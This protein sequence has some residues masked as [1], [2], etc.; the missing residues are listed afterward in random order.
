MRANLPD[1]F[2]QPAVKRWGPYFVKAA[3]LL[4]LLFLYTRVAP[5]L[6]AIGI[7]L[8]WTAL[9]A[10][11]AILAVYQT[12]IAKCHKQEQF[13][14]GGLSSRMN[15]GRFVALLVALVVS[16]FCMASLLLDAPKWEATEWCVVIL[17]APLFLAASLVV[18]KVKDREFEKP[19]QESKSTVA[20]CVLTVIFLFIVYGIASAIAAHF[21]HPAPYNS[22][23]EAFTSAKQPF[24]NSPSVLMSQVGMFTALVDGLAAYTLPFIAETSFPAFVVVRVVLVIATFTGIVGLLGTCSLPWSELRKAFLP[25]EAVKKQDDSC[26]VVKPFVA[27]AIVLTLC[28]PA[29]FLA[30]ESATAK[31]VET[32][33][34]T[35]IEKFIRGQIGVAACIIDDIPYD[36]VAVQDALEEARKRSENLAAEAEKTL[37]PLINEAYDARLANVDKYLDWYYSLPADYE[38]LAQLVTGSVEDYVEEQFTAAIE[39]GID[40]S[41]LSEEMS[42]YSEEAEAIKADLMEVLSQYVIEDVPEW[43]IVEESAITSSALAEPLEP[44]Q[45]LLDWRARMGTS[46]AVGVGTGVVA[47]VLIEKVVKKSFFSK[48]VTRIAT[49]VGSR[50]AA[51]AGGGAI[52]TAFGPLGTIAGIALGTIAGVGADYGMLKLDEWQNREEYKAEIVEAIEEARIETLAMVQ[53][54]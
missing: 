37:V 1:T 17:S 29:A 21:Q 50:G 22:A 2:K 41:R 18:D 23:I 45:K 42:R 52:G 27:V 39:D 5:S 54:S 30:L 11:A 24:E 36:P 13:K 51:A 31:A 38:R 16:A 25:V 53:S 12:V 10:V 44:T 8:I 3:V 7:A 4:G 15:G 47:K 49:A 35:A 28:V 33:E 20:S 26:P 48:I 9:T 34:Y 19:Y 40:N 6:P 14:S 46:A 32:E 43:L